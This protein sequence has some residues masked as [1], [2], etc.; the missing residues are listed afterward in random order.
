MQTLPVKADGSAGNQKDLGFSS[1]P[2]LAKG[3]I[4]ISCSGFVWACSCKKQTL[5]KDIHGFIC[6]I[7]CLAYLKDDDADSDR[8]FRSKHSK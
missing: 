1:Q 6:L 4:G 7:L 2:H 3:I 8:R 5:C